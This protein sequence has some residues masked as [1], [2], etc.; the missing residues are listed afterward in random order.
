MENS[1][2]NPNMQQAGNNKIIT[3]NDNYEACRSWDLCA[4][5]PNPELVKLFFQNLRARGISLTKFARQKQVNRSKLSQILHGL[6]VPKTPAKRK[7][8]AEE[9]LDFDVQIFWIPIQTEE[10]FDKEIYPKFQ[11]DD[12]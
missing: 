12:K 8:W 2:L 10:E 11:E 1:N 3:P 6:D 4:V 7:F 5:K 9:V